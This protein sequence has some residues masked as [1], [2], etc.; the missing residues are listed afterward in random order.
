MLVIVLSAAALILATGMFEYSSG[1]ASLNQ[2][3]NEYHQA[4]TAAEAATEK[5]IARIG[6]D[7]RDKGNS[8]V[9]GHLDSYRTYIPT[10]Q[11]FPAFQDYVFRDLAR[12][13]D[14]VEVSYLIGKGF[15]LS[16][17]RFAG[18]R[19]VKNNLRVTAN[20]TLRNRNDR[21]VGSVYQDIELLRIPLFQFAVFY[22]MD[23]EIDNQPPMVITG[24]VHCN[25]NMY[26]DP[27]GALTFNSDVTCAGTIY[28]N[29]MP[30]DPLPAGSGPVTYLARHQDHVSTLNLPIGTNSDPTS[31]HSLI[32]VPPVLEDPNSLMGKE[33]YYNKADLIITIGNAA[34]SATSGLFNNFATPIPLTEVTNFV[35]T[36]SSFYNKRELKTVA[37]TDIDIAK[38]GLWNATNTSLRPVLGKGDVQTLFVVD[39]R[40]PGAMQPGIRLINGQTLPPQGLTVATPNPLYIQGH[41]NAPAGALGTTNTSATLPSSVAADA[42]TILSTAWSDLNSN[43]SLSNRKA[44][45][46]TVNA[47]IL[48]GLV[49]TTTVSHSGGVENFPRFLE[50][51]TGYTLTYNGS[52]VAMFFS[53]SAT[54]LWRGTGGTYD[55]Y[56]PPNRNWA[57][58]QNFGIESRIPPS[59]P[60]VIV[61]SRGNWRMPAPYS[62]NVT[63]GF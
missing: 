49:G 32:E 8:Y 12:H 63:A 46:T 60:S 19:G 15:S 5:V 22:N 3:N 10:P 40:T 17:G 27:F 14:R 56:N 58:D 1:T 7:Y 33:R 53:K 39:Q 45:N 16:S 54:N 13:D 31:I 42:V 11:E 57:L 59:T 38:L 34:I 28:P 44:A 41:F 52:M 43:K 20:A 18:L 51:W 23:L 48:T 4:V 21:P 47:G 55:I 24:P 9:L 29:H 26:V 61:L 35:S 62:T 30:G 2:R 36:N 6:Q 50:E 37:S 25:T